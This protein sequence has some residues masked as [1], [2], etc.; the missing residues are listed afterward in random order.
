MKQYKYN[1]RIHL[2]CRHPILR[3]PLPPNINIQNTF[4][5]IT[6]TYKHSDL[7]QKGSTETDNCY[8]WLSQIDG[9]EYNLFESEIVAEVMCEIPSW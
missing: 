8:M 6:A 2:L 4:G 5:V 1:H 9:K 3:L 7:F